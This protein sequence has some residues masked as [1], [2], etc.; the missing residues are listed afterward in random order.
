MKK[1]LDQM[2]QFQAYEAIH[3]DS[4]PEVQ[5]S[6]VLDFIWFINPKA[7]KSEVDFVLVY[8]INQWNQTV[9]FMRAH[10]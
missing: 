2:T 7:A 1:E 8:F 9:Q 10:H 4:V 3:T 6:Q 5:T